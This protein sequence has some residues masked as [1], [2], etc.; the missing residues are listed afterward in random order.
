MSF[1][2]WLRS[3]T[4]L[5]SPRR[6]T[7]HRPAA[8]R[9]R[10]QLECLEDRWL[11]STLTVTNNLDSGPGSLRAEIAAANAKSKD[12]VVFAPG[13]DGQTIT[14]TS[15]GLLINKDLTIAGPGAGQLTVSGGGVSGVFYVYSPKKTINVALS[16]L[17]ISNGNN[18]G[19]TGGAIYNAFEHLTLSGCTLP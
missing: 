10:P 12:T 7:Q 19:G 4:W 3:R 15:G 6:R 18:Q 16:G 8:P 2:S 1:V 9:F 17:T 5:R 14:L 11:P 13:L